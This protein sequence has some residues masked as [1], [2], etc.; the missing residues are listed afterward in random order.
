MPLYTQIF[1]ALVAA[2]LF[3]GIFT[4]YVDYVTWTGDVFLRALKMIVIP[5]VFLSVASGVSGLRGAGIGRLGLRT[6]IYYTATSI[7]AISTGIFFANWLEVGDDFDL[8]LEE[9]VD[10]SDLEALGDDKSFGRTLIEIIP[11]NIV[12][13]FAEGSMLPTIFFALIVGIFMNRLAS[14]SSQR[15]RTL[16]R[17]GFD[18]I[19]KITE[20][21][22][23][24]T[25]VGVFGIVS[26]V[27]ADQIQ[28]GGLAELAG[29][30]GMYFFTVVGALAFHAFILLPAALFLIGRVNPFS[31]L[32]AMRSVLLT[33]FSTASSNATLPLT[34]DTVE[35]E[36]GV[37]NRV[38]G[39]V[40]PLGATVNMDGTA[41]YE[42]VAALFI[43]EVY[44]IDLTVTQQF[45]I[46]L[47]ALLSSVGTAG[48][49]MASLVTISII[50][51]A[52]GLPFEGMA[53]LLA[54]DRILD[55]CRTMVNVWSDTC[56]AVIIAG[57]EGEKLKVSL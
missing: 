37:S 15:L 9:N 51:D 52:V 30:L 5:L 45:I 20:F 35:N 19:M 42:C 29:S 44:D 13:A 1:I 33:A 4:D 24:F 10:I 23:L 8:N 3:G 6:L 32:K 55:M 50:L 27:I 25:P 43:A 53:L 22:L 41:L 14:D 17:D 7:F 48:I 49:P 40:L 31:H 28:K 57:L 16:T 39:F 2:V 18:L 46:V 36:A 56:G 11:E 12:N 47:T 54:V 26:G 38:S 34:M 21:V